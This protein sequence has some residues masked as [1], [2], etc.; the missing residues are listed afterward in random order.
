[1]NFEVVQKKYEKI[2]VEC[3]LRFVRPAGIILYGGYGRNEGSW[4]VIDNQS[5]KPYNDFDILLVVN[6]QLN[7]DIIFKIKEHLKSKI[8]IRWIDLTQ[9]KLKKL[10][11]L[12]N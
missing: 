4:L 12:K 1:M 10:K 3:I 11:K 2:I 5:P 9:I 7:G 6:K 8:S